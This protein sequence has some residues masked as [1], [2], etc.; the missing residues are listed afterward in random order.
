MANVTESKSRKATPANKQTKLCLHCGRVKPLTD[1]Y[2]NRDWE[3][4]L[5]KDIWCKDCVNR[6]TTKDEMREYFWENHRAW[7]ERIWD[8]ANKKA[9]S[10]AANNVTYQKTTEERRKLIIE[11]LTCQQIPCL[12]QTRYQYIDPTKDGTALSYAEAKENGEI[13]EEADPNVKVYSEEF[14]GYF[15][16]AELRYLETYYQSLENDF[17]LDTEN[18]RDYARKLSKASLLADKAQDDY[19][20]GRCSYA[21]VKDALAQF[22]MLSKSA[23]FAACKRKAGDNSGMTSY[24]E[25]SYKLETT[26]HTMQR[27]VQWEEDDVDRVI[28]HFRHLAAAMNFDSI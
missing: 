10:L 4:Q 22:D 27:K 12:M 13:I 14:N 19:A 6:C 28:N 9:A 2:S 5:G 25:L 26:G 20:A 18:L 24:S 15:K 23:N 21:D 1:Y 3:E 17:D 7:D 8:A 11:R 16:P